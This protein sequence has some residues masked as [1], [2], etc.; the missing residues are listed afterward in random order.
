[1]STRIH[2]FVPRDPHFVPPAADVEVA[3]AWLPSEV[4]AYKIEAVTP[5]HVI[6]FDCGGG[7]GDVLCP[8]CRT[9]IGPLWK[10]WM[11]DSY[12]DEGG[13]ALTSQTLICCGEDVRLDQ[14]IFVS[15]CAF[16]SF[17]IDMIDTM[18]TLSDAEV[19]ALMEQVEVLLSC[20]LQHV[21]AHY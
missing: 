9:D 12:T 6:F 21:D 2:R 20:K 3:L 15:H 19:A 4:D 5:G 7:L 8:K 16:G 11:D 1:M 13:F 18:T 14:L 17:G 10:E